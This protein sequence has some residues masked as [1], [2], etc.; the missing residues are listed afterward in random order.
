MAMLEQ[1]SYLFASARAN[2]GRAA[3]WG[4]RQERRSLPAATHYRVGG[5]VA[6]RRLGIWLK[7]EARPLQ[8]QGLDLV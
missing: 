8:G 6:Q 3:F 7:G 5:K 2:R 4:A 1:V